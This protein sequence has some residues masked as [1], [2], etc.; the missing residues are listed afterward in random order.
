[1]KASGIK[2]A[3]WSLLALSLV[4]VILYLVFAIITPLPEKLT[5]HFICDT[6]AVFGCPLAGNSSLYTGSK[7]KL[8]SQYNVTSGIP[9]RTIKT[10][11]FTLDVIPNSHICIYYC[12]QGSVDAVITEEDYQPILTPAKPDS[13][14]I[15]S[16]ALVY[17]AIVLV[18]IGMLITACIG[19][20]PITQ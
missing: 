15:T 18:C 11:N 12:F 1:M 4:F 7:I 6:Q 2:A 8:N 5:K 16:M 13:S 14:A 9:P 3:R 10:L 17:S 20:R 19:A